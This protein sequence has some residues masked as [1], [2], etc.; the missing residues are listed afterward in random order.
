MNSHVAYGTYQ[1]NVA[2]GE[3]AEYIILHTGVAD[4]LHADQLHQAELL[5]HRTAQDFK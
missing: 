2:T 3:P 4:Y 1:A 5:S